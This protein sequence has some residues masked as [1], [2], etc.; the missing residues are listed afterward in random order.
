MDILKS[1][2]DLHSALVNDGNNFLLP[3]F[4]LILNFLKS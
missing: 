1:D 3:R 4:F 2:G